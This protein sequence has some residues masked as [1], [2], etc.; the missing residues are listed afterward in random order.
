MSNQSAIS[1][2]VRSARHQDIPF[3][4]RMDL[5]ASRAP[6]DE[7]F[8]EKLLATTGTSPTQFIEAMFS[9]EASCW[10]RIEDFLIIERNG[11]PVATCAVFRPSGRPEGNSPLNL[12]KLS[13]IAELLN[14]DTS[15]TESFGQAYAEMWQDSN[16]FLKPQAEMI[17]ET[18]AVSPNHRGLGLGHSL[19]K[20]AF[21]RARKQ[22]A[23]S[24]GVMVIHG[25]KPAQALYEQ[26]FE[27]YATFHAAFF[28]HAFPGLT[29]YRA[30]LQLTKEKQ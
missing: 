28:E 6:F 19:M 8:W 23:A 12:G 14:W 20:A 29:K 18:V 21:K 1:E 2:A 27:P 26:Y 4:A 22:G 7:S 16:S 24:L 11:Q 30:N 10:G 5:E 17:V 25:N 3:I 9:C 15:T 13:Q